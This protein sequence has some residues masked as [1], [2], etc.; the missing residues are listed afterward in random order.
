MWHGCMESNHLMLPSLS[1]QRLL[2]SCQ[3]QERPHWHQL[4]VSL[5][6]VITFTSYAGWG[7]AASQITINHWLPSSVISELPLSIFPF[8][9]NKR[10]VHTSIKLQV[11]TKARGVRSLRSWS[12]RQ[13]WAM[14]RG[15]WRSNL[16]SLW[17]Q[18]TFLAVTISAASC[19]HILNVCR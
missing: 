11:S 5:W 12:D 1:P 4:N 8:V 18:Y 14:Q 16:G 3:L 13:L 17:E 6:P 2:G 7:L 10:C 19:L 15:C 9:C